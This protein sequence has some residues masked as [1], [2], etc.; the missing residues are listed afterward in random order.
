M[1]DLTT[2]SLQ[3]CL[4]QASDAAAA[5]TMPLFRTKLEIDN[6]LGEG[7][8]PVTEADRQAEIAIRDII[9]AHFPDHAITGEEQAD[10]A[11]QNGSPYRWIIDPVDGT[12]AFMSGLPVW[13]TLIGVTQ[14]DRAIAGLMSQPFTR[15]AY[16]A[17][18][19]KS[20]LVHDNK[21]THLRVSDT[22]QLS[23]ATMFTVTPALFSIP[24]QR[25]AFDA[26]EKKVQLSRYGV[27]CYAY[28]LLAGGHIDLIIEPSMNTYDIA[29]LVPLIENAGGVVSTWDGNR[30]EQGGDIIAAATP[31]L[32]DAALE[33]MQEHTQI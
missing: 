12:R 33:V 8:D 15:E 5:K 3:E 1:P 11:P 19:G 30:A 7:F 4:L 28:A 29:A 2:Q 10:K 17:I 6:K 14:N 32:R 27:D 25:A 24:E 31:E 22:T 21:T 9:H 13:G 16:L 26:V 20:E 18:D 23:T